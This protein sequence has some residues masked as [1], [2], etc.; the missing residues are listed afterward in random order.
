[1][2]T[3]PYELL[4]RFAKSGTVAGAHVKLM[5]M[6]ESGRDL[7]E[8]EAM[9]LADAQN[10]PVFHEFSKQFASQALAERDV[11]AA[12]VQSLQ[13]HIATLTKQIEE[14]NDQI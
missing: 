10:D 4:V 3:R 1:M 12:Q 7:I 8:T 6:D 13:A 11:L 14:S 9:P 2:A 5:H